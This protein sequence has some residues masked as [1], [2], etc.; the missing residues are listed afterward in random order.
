MRLSP[1]IRGASGLALSSR[2]HLRSQQA[3]VGKGEAI[4]AAYDYDAL[5]VRFLPPLSSEWVLNCS[6]GTVL[7]AFA[8]DHRRAAKPRRRAESCRQ[9]LD[10][11]AAF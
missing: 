10:P 9:A 4:L 3:Q 6:Y 11:E 8:R 7:R 1:A 2:R 5:A